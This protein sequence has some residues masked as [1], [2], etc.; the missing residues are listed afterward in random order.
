MFVLTVIIFNLYVEN[1][2][3]RVAESERSDKDIENSYRPLYPVYSSN[4]FPL[5][6]NLLVEATEVKPIKI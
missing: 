6:C 2:E 5:V 4:R 3:Y 1:P